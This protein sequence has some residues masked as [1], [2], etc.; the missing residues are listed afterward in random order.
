MY[1][2]GF[3]HKSAHDSCQACTRRALVHLARSRTMHLLSYCQQDTAV[4]AVLLNV[5]VLVKYSIHVVGL[6]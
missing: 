3:A 1:T 4:E 2:H 5:N 6:R